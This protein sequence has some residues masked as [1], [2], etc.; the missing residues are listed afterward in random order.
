MHSAALA[1]AAFASLRPDDLAQIDFSSLVGLVNEPNMPSGGGATIRRVVDLARL[2]SGCNVLEIGSNT[3]FTS[4]EFASWIDG[5]AVGVDIN[6]IS[7]AFAKDKAGRYG[8]ENVTFD[9]GDGC[10]LP[11][12]DD[13]FDLVYCSN[14]TSFIDDRKRA[15]DEYYRVLGPRGV[16]AAVPIYYHLDPP[17]ELRQKVG[18]AIGADLPITDQHYWID[19]FDD[20]TAVLVEHETYEYERQTP[21]RIAAYVEMILQQP[22]LKN[23]DPVLREAAGERLSYFYS[24]FDE[25]LS[26][27]RYDILIY[28]RNHPNPE[29]VLHTS[30]RVGRI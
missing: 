12:P 20:P 22:H 15:R 29:P 13:T 3:G 19:L 16:L 6:P 11:Y 30:R 1:S 5:K 21:E 23:L 2:R 25:N 4:I 9:V 26:Y 17:D 8:V 27:A 24:L 18:E 14:V 7:V 28:R 10:H